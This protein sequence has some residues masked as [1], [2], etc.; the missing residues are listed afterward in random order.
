MKIIVLFN[1]KPGVSVSDYEDWAR[2]RDIPD[3]N[4]LS[5]VSSF[6][7]HRATG[8]FGSDAASPYAYIE[9]IDIAAMDP[10]IADIS[11]PEFQAMAAPFQDYADNPQFILTEDL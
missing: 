3:V 1:L 8:L 4:A 9:I 6:T 5:S 10:F 7:V 11:T 2:T